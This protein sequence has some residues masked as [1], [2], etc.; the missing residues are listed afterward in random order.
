M[1]E[2]PSVHRAAAEGF[3]SGAEVYVRGR[4]DYP[5]QALDWL[6]N[7]LG[8]AV[9]RAVVDLGAGTGKFTRVLLATGAKVIAVDPV[10]PM[11]DR[12][13]RDVPEVEAV[14]GDA[15]HIP[16]AAGSV[17]AVACAQSFHWFATPAAVAEI[18]RVL[19]PGG[20]LG[21]IW[22][23]R[24]DSERW[25][26]GLG[27]IF[28]RYQG[29]AP[30]MT[31]GEWRKVFPAQ[32]FGPLHEARFAHAHIG[33]PERVIVDR[34]MSVSFMAALPTAERERA[35]AEVRALI[36]ATPSLAGRA[37]VSV[38]YVTVAFHCFASNMAVA[39]QPHGES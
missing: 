5:P 33:P 12:L 20:A 21:L 27:R 26:A 34:A 35:L 30:R 32:G 39:R 25:V 28:E 19:K 24:D 9:G 1:S 23:Q 11:L 15:E 38:P 14:A 7:S 17:D 31:S 10:M 4:P 3:S 2:N 36:D 37:E 13:R 29:D 18:R 8:L 6:R 16:L 22:N